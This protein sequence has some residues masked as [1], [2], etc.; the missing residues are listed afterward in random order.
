MILAAYARA[1]G[2]QD[3]V[4]PRRAQRVTDLRRV[5]A[6]P[7]VRLDDPTVAHGERAQHRRIRIVDLERTLGLP[8][9]DDVVTGDDDPHARRGDDVHMRDSERRDQARVLRPQPP[10]R[11]ENGRARANVLA[12]ATDMP[13]GRDGNADFDL[14]T[15]QSRVLG[16]YDRVGA[17]WNRG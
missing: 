8:R 13:A 5:V 11:F 16:R 17:G 2:Q 1:A 15:D 3:D 9:T 7:Q 10:A 4:G 14:R 12:A 6:D